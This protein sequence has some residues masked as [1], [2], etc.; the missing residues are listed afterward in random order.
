MRVVSGP[1]DWEA[2][3]LSMT[4]P[5]E[6]IDLGRWKA[7]MIPLR[8]LIRYQPSRGAGN[9]VR[10]VSHIIFPSLGLANYATPP[11]ACG[12]KVFAAEG[13]LYTCLLL[14]PTRPLL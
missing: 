6:E 14:R 10:N 1:C 11:S 13:A 12:C 7:P 2:R 4:S 3:E 8:S 9:P 5:N